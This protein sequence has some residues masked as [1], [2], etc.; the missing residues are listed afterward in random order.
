MSPEIGWCDDP[1][2]IPALVAFFIANVDPDYISHGELADGRAAAPGHWSPRLADIL[3]AEF[4]ACEFT[5]EAPGVGKRLVCARDGG[6]IIGIALVE[7]SDPGER[8]AVIHDLVVGRATRGRGVGQRILGWIE[9]AAM[10][11]DCTRVQ[12]ES[13]ITNDGAHRFFERQGFET[14]SVV[15]SKTLGDQTR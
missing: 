5:H 11:A 15:M 9:A 8:V 7:V 3:A 14:I 12:I 13:G 4:A 10:A 1:A 2:E 6:G